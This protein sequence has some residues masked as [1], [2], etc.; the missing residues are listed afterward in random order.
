MS[1]KPETLLWNRLKKKIPQD[2]HLTRIENRFGGG[3][4]DVF[5]CAEGVPFWIELKTTKNYRLNLSS[6]QIAWH[7]AFYRSGGVS[8]FLAHPLSSPNLYLFGGEQGRELV[9]NGLRS[10]ESGLVVRCRWSGDDWS[11][12]V[13]YMLEEARS[14]VGVG[15]REP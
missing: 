7:Y 11:G 5:V 6:H 9:V 8:F 15:V 12:L 14:R 1:Q 13:E 3:I 4:P 2:W 10:G